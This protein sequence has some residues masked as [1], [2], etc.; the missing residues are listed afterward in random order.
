MRGIKEMG[1]WRGAGVDGTGGKGTFREET[2][3]DGTNIYETSG[4]GA[5]KR[6]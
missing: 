2:H 1:S 4:G 3:R 5:Q 6:R